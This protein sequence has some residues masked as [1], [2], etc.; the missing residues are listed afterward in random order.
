M[1]GFGDTMSFRSDDDHSLSYGLRSFPISA[2]GGVPGGRE[3]NFPKTNACSDL[4]PKS[5][6]PCRPGD[7]KRIGVANHSSQAPTTG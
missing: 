7:G 6:F 4:G 3:T 1:I 2:R 5:S